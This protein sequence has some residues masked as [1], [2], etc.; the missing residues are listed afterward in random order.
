M[1]PCDAL[2]RLTTEMRFKGL[3]SLKNRIFSES[4]S[5]THT[6][7]KVF[8]TSL[9]TQCEVSVWNLFTAAVKVVSDTIDSLYKKQSPAAL[10]IDLS[11]A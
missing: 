6:T 4:S 3:E 7:Y 10:F 11:K 1:E 2:I 8:D 9:N 5:C